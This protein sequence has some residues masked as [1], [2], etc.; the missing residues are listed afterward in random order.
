MRRADLRHVHLQTGMLTD[1][2]PG[3][4]RM[5]EMNV[6]QEQVAQVG[7]RQT[8]LGETLL[9]RRQAGGR[10]TV[11]ERRPVCRLQH[12]DADDALGALVLEVERIRGAHAPDPM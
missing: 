3:G 7:E 10:P 1:E 9:Q 6:R 5:V 2:H 8:L 12:V 11:E 4:T